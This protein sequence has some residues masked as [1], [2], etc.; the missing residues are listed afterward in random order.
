MSSKIPK[1]IFDEILGNVHKKSAFDMFINYNGLNPKRTND[2]ME[3]VLRNA[4]NEYSSIVNDSNTKTLFHRLRYLEQI[5]S[6]SRAV[7]YSEVKLSEVKQESGR[8]KTNYV[9]AR[10]PFFQ[11]H[12]VKPE[13]RIYLGKTK[14]MEKTIEE[15]EQDNEFM[16]EAEILIVKEM[17]K[18]IK[19]NIY[20]EQRAH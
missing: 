6:Q 8:G 2:E 3:K 18:I 14:E 11:P 10:A 16:E 5:I 17:E 7:I 19:K 13:L 20:N 4:L 12:L 1:P 15:L 9:V